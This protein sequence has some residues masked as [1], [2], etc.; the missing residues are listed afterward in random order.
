MFLYTHT[1]LK[2]EYANDL[3]LTCIAHEFQ[4]HMYKHPYDCV[5]L[6]AHSHLLVMEEW[7]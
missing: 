3:A 6:N 4:I 1:A 5:Y 2:E 7:S